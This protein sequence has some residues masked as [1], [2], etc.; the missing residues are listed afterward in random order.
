VIYFGTSGFSYSDW[1][2]TV[3]PHDLAKSDWLQFY[4][5]EFNSLELNSTYYAI[6]GLQAIQSMVN[7]TGDGFQFAVKANQEITH[8]RQPDDLTF[9]MFIR[10]LQ[11]L[12][13]SGKFG[14]VLA[15]F[16]YSFHNT[17]EN[18]EY[19]EFIRE[20]LKDIPLVIEFRNIHWLKPQTFEWLKNLNIGFCCV[21]EPE[22]PNLIPPVSEITSDIA[23]IRFHGR[24]AAKWWQHEQAYERYDYTYTEG[25]LLE[26]IPKIVKLNRQAKKTFVFANNHWQ[27]QSVDTIR[28]LRLMIE[29]YIESGKGYPNNR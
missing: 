3:Y 11:P 7:K 18:I 12:I 15:E 20:K 22:L 17:A 13:H 1:V 2:G 26:W 23:Y 19:I 16:P 21:D 10:I 25:E 28:Q 6:P 29:K 27:G 24:N 9:Q 14:C 5:G 4:S 8:N